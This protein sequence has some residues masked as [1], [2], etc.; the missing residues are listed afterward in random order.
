MM[1]RHFYLMRS[2]WPRL[3]ELIYWP[4]VQMLMWGFLQTYL[5][6]HSGFIAAAGGTL[7]G[8]ILLWDVLIRGQLGLSVSF[9]EEMWSR[10]M[11]NL[12]ISPLGPGEFVAA[13]MAMS[14]IRLVVSIVPVT[15]LAIWFFG[16]NLWGLGFGLAAF[17]ANLLLSGWAVGIVVSGL[18]LRNG[19]G[20][21]GL[22][23]TLMFLILPLCAVFY[24][25]TV[26]PAF[27]Q[28]VAWAL[29]PTYVFE[30]MRAILIDHTFRVDLMVEA[31]VINAGFITVAIFVFLRLVDSARRIG[32]L[33]AI[34]E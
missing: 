19:L 17:F 4:L 34:G 32:S 20:A 15:L 23:W 26:L 22:A 30:G 28:P 7:I 9:L 1:L 27:L 14:L 13:L 12:L 8:A 33:M 18:I 29:P 31:L 6:Q 10:N 2:S 5:N 25:V 11:A 3:L 16:F 24:P 21:E